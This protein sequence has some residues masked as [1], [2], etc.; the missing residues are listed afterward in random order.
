MLSPSISTKW[1]S[2]LHSLSSL[3]GRKAALHTSANVSDSLERV[4][5]LTVKAYS[6]LFF[7]KPLTGHRVSKIL[8]GLFDPKKNI[9]PW[10]T[11][12]RKRSFI[13]VN[14]IQILWFT[15]NIFNYEKIFF[16]VSIHSNIFFWSTIYLLVT[17]TL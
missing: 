4:F 17:Q 6:S 15:R 3:L 5:L 7:L 11:I 16:N 8:P 1:P 14:S 12:R 10:Y 9:W 13:P 2:W